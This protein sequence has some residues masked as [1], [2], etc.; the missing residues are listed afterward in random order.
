[1]REIIEASYIER[2]GECVHCA[3]E[4]TKHIVHSPEKME[5]SSLRVRYYLLKKYGNPDVEGSFHWTKT[6][7]FLKSRVKSEPEDIHTQRIRLIQDAGFGIEY[8]RV[9]RLSPELL[10]LHY[11]KYAGRDFFEP[12]VAY[13][14]GS[15]PLNA[16]DGDCTILILSYPGDVIGA[17]REFFGGMGSCEPWQLRYTAYRH[18]DPEVHHFNVVHSSDSLIAAIEEAHRFLGHDVTTEHFGEEEVRRVV[19]KIPSHEE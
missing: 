9:M 8:Q 1:V 19:W 18:P 11:A 13:L 4:S 5:A 6:F 17:S 15:D 12:M 10:R 16:D 14:S 3:Y 7:T 2:F